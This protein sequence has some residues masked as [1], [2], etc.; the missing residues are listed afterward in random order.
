MVTL[1]AQIQPAALAPCFTWS[2][3]EGVSEACIVPSVS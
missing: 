2:P 3:T 1:R